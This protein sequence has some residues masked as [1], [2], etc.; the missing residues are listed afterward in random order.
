[1]MGYYFVGT[2]D[3]LFDICSSFTYTFNVWWV[4]IKCILGN[5]EMSG[6]IWSLE[7]G[8]RRVTFTSPIPF[9]LKRTPNPKKSTNDYA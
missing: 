1:M 2:G 8:K 3:Y 5:W 6:D 9:C 7:G 4:Y